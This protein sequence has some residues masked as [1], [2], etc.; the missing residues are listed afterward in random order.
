MFKVFGFVKKNDNLSHDDYRAAHV[1]YHNSFGRRLKNIRGYILNVRSNRNLFRDFNYPKVIQEVSMN[2]PKNFDSQWNGFGQLMF[3][4]YDGYIKAKQSS[5]DKAGPNGLEY[6][7]M[8]AKVGDDF[9]YLYSGSPIQFNVNETVINP[10]MRPEKKLFKI[11]QFIKKKDQFDYSSYHSYIKEKYCS[12]F[13][14]IYGLKGLI[15]NH[16]T[17]IDVM[18]NF[19][20]PDAECFSNIGMKRREKFFSCWD[21]IIEY[22]FLNYDNFF[23]ERLEK[24]LITKANKFENKYF[25]RSFYREVDETIAVIPKRDFK[26][27]FYHR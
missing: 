12:M 16:R 13:A 6:D 9:N 2:E 20:K 22:W 27:N 18:K 10:V 14:G 17:S 7:E 19:F 15:V 5:L 23:Q 1:G 24:K 21:S 26:P 11:I 4:D 8:V 25:E 3:D